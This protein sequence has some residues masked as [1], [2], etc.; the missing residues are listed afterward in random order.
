[1]KRQVRYPT[2]KG[3]AWLGHD[4]GDTSVAVSPDDPA[5]PDFE[6]W[7]WHKFDTIKARDEWLV[8]TGPWEVLTD[9]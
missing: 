8:S 3:Y 7:A 5:G 6:F 9:G 2:T 4:E 1:M